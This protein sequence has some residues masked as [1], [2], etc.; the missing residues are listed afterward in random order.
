LRKT[1]ARNEHTAANDERTLNVRQ[2][3]SLPEPFSSI[4]NHNVQF[5]ESRLTKFLV[6]YLVA[7]IMVITGSL[8]ACNKAPELP[9]PTTRTTRIVSP[10]AE[11]LNNDLTIG[12]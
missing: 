6:P 12:R 5:F 11:M 2:V 10:Y 7:E 4:L 3:S 1:S 9:A 8:L